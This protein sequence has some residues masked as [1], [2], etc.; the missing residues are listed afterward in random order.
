MK[1]IFISL[2]L[3][4]SITTVTRA[5]KLDTHPV[6]L[7]ADGKLLPWKPYNEVAALSW[8]LLLKRIPVDPANGLK[9]YFTHCEYDPD[10]F[11]GSGWPNNPAGKNA[12]LADSA[13]LWFQYTGDTNVVALVRSLLDHQLAHGTT[14][15]NYAWPN[16]P[17]S[18]ARAGSVEYGNDNTVEGVGVLEPDKLG[19]LGYHG[20]LRFYELTGDTR[21]RN[22][23]I[24]CADT[25][26]AHRRDGDAT[27]SPWPYRVN[28]QTGAVVEEYCAHV[29]API[30]LF[31]ELI[32]LN[33]GNVAAYRAARQA[34]WTWLMTHPMK[35]N[36]WCQYFEDVPVQGNLGN[37]NQYNPGQTAR[38]LLE[39]PDADPQWREH[40]AALIAWIESNFGSTD[41]GE[42]GLQYGAR[43]ISEQNAYK[44]KMCSHSSRFGAVNALYA[45]ATGDAAAKD[46]AFRTLNWCTYMCRDNGA[47]IEGPAEF[48]QNRN[49]WFTD[50]HG[51]YIRHF[52]LALGAFPE[53]SPAN[54]NHLVRSTSVV[55]S[56][57]YRDDRIAYETF[58]KIATEIFRLAAAPRHVLA[59]GQPL[60]AA[61]WQH[62]KATGILRVRHDN[63]SRI[64]IHLAR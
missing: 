24:A 14:P 59:D 8:E 25:L 36:I 53:W 31:D 64:E 39:H 4:L 2:V 44:F 41:S 57:V 42:P 56:I 21:Y 29:I 38:Y 5:A 52:M 20:Y 48:R 16:V 45:A 12:M 11:T 6:R 50:G 18:T 26:A 10:T 35:N 47:V 43:V 34:A 62:D 9:V 58:D 49:N 63:A 15:A 51:D 55:K 33:L 19:E 28:A 13:L 54:E 46:K 27:K 17:W 40:T 1:N 3:L 60:P 30:R 22:A 37:L 61:A 32:R 7:D 23:A